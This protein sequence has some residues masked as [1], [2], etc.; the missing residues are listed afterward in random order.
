MALTEQ[1]I[2]GHFIMKNDYWT[3]LSGDRGNVLNYLTLSHIV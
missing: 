1:I 3:L 2:L